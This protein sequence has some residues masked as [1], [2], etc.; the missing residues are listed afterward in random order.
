[1]EWLAWQG[2]EA[3]L[4]YNHAWHLP[5]G[6]VLDY[7]AIKNIMLGNAKQKRKEKEFWELMEYK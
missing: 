2:M 6:E 5:W 1:M 3:G 4:S 7:A